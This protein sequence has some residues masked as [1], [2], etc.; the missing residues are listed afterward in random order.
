MRET[1]FGS[2]LPG[3]IDGDFD[4][5][6]VRGYLRGIGGN[7]NGQ[8]EAL[9]S[10]TASDEPEIVEFGHP[11]LEGGRRVPQ[12]PAIV[13]IVSRANGDH[14]PVGD[15]TK[16]HHFEGD[17]QRLVRTPVTGQRGAHEAR[18][19]GLDEFAGTGLHP[20]SGKRF[21]R[22]RQSQIAA[23]HE[24]ESARTDGLRWQMH[25]GKAGK[26]AADVNHK[27]LPIKNRVTLV[28]KSRQELADDDC[29]LLVYCGFGSPA[30]C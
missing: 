23:T 16:A 4:G 21:F 22:R 9:S 8:V 7:M 17:R 6:V 18:A 28:K 25:C 2:R 10:P 1:R 24:S 13:L 11:I 26:P 15:V 12:L 29:C 27:A 19:A 20:Y 30:C 14:R 5:F 3:S